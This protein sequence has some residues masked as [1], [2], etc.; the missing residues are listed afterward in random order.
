MAEHSRRS[1]R[2]RRGRSG[3]FRLNAGSSPYG[4]ASVLE[5]NQPGGSFF[6]GR[7]AGGGGGDA[8]ARA[9]SAPAA[10]IEGPLGNVGPP[11][12]ASYSEP[13]APE[14]RPDAPSYPEFKPTPGPEPT[15]I[16]S[17][18]PEFTPTPYFDQVRPPSLYPTY[19]PPRL[20]Q[21]TRG[22][23]LSYF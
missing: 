3:V 2:S 19:L 8:I 23:R 16:A 10:S 9:L 5:M 20:P 21:P 22:G 6:A 12:Q 13:V 4:R 14:Q 18:F 7:P 11:P 17:L 1:G 15:P